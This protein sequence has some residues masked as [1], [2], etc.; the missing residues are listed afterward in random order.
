[1]SSKIV[2]PLFASAYHDDLGTEE[3]DLGF[4]LLS[5]Y[6]FDTDFGHPTQSIQK[7]TFESKPKLGAKTSARKASTS[8]SKSKNAPDISEDEGFD[9]CF[10]TA[11]II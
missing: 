8:T 5:E 3:L 10:L 9:K 1:M 11:N 4:G 2:P 7:E 6:L